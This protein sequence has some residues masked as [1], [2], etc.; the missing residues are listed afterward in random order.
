MGTEPD[1]FPALLPYAGLKV[2]DLS[3]GVA[4]PYCAS[5][6]ALSGADVIK[7]EPPAGDWCRDLGR[8][9][10]GLGALAVASNLGKRS[11]VVDAARP[12]GRALLLAM[13]KRADVLIENFRPGVIARLGLEDAVIRPDNPRLVYASITG[14]GDSGPWARKAGTD[15]VLQAYTGMT[16]VNRGPDGAP[17]RFGLLVPDTVT[18]LYALQAVQAALFARERTGAGR[19]IQVSLAQCC[20]A[21]QCAPIVDDALFPGEAAPPNNVPAGVFA[22]ADGFVALLALTDA[23]WTSVCRAL[24]EEEWLARPEYATHPQRAARCDE[25]NRAVAGRLRAEATQA[26]LERFERHDVLCAEVLDYA[27]F[28]EH[29]QTRHMGWFASVA[30]PPYGPL[31]V[32]ELPGRD[33]AAPLPPAP[34][35]GEHTRA[36]LAGFGHTPEAVAALEQAGVVVQ[37]RW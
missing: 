14:F 11:I 19:H 29:P 26:W 4:G 9:R 17:R 13:A 28:R 33:R 20:A 37:G 16:M 36:I 31:E 1:P 24:G 5:M 22:T 12:E 35:L 23:M 18:A 30:Q 6:L 32:P 15:S 7:V 10:D 27:R 25:I 3:Q 21:F 2:L 34:R 8:G